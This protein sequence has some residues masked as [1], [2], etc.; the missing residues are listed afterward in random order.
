VIFLP[1]GAAR[2]RRPAPRAVLVVRLD[3]PQP[4]LA[5]GEQRRRD[6]LEVRRDRGERLVEAR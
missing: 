3:E 4:A 5:A 2:P 6:L 1:A